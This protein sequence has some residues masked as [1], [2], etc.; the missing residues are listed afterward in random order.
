[1]RSEEI[2]PQLPVRVDPHERLT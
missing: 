1:M 2:L